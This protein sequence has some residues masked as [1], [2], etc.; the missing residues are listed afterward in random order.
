MIINVFVV[1]ASIVG[2]C[3][4]T[5]MLFYGLIFGIIKKKILKYSKQ[6]VYDEIETKGLKSILPYVFGS[7]LYRLVFDYKNQENYFYTGS[8]AVLVGGIFIILSS[9]LIIILLDI[10]LNSRLICF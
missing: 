4:S 1:V 3:L 2:I 9:I 6:Y 5:A 7:Y 8:T 10:I